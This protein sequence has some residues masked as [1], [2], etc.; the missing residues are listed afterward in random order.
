MRAICNHQ[1]RRMVARQQRG[2]TVM[3]CVDCKADIARRAHRK[4]IGWQ[5]FWDRQHGLCAFCGQPLAD[6]NTTHLDH[7]H[8]TGRKRGLVHSQCNLA[9]GGVEVALKLVPMERLIKYLCLQ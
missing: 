9:I 6:D 2:R 8:A 5:E 3:I 1:P 4:K 7:D